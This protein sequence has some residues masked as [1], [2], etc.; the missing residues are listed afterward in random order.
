MVSPMVKVQI[1]L[2]NR[3]RYSPRLVVFYEIELTLGLMLGID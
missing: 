2:T 3:I 1:T